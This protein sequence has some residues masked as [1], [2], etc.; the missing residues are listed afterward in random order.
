MMNPEMLQR[1]PSRAVMVGYGTLI[2][3][4]T[5]ET[6]DTSI[7]DMTKQAKALFAEIMKQVAA[8]VECL[9]RLNKSAFSQPAPC[10]CGPS[11]EPV[12]EEEIGERK[13]I[14]KDDP[15]VA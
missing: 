3:T 4:V 5:D 7:K 1:P 12:I 2:V 6:H 8:N 14:D 10:K 11:A 15:A 13:P 9:E